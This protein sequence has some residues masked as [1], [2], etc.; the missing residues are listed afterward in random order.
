MLALTWTTHQQPGPAA[1]AV[2]GPDGNLYIAT[3]AGDGAGAIL[4]VT[5]TA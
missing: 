2:Q 5:P 1:V 4:V 3:N